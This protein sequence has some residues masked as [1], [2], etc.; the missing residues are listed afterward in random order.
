MY[1]ESSKDSIVEGDGFSIVCAASKF[2]YSNVSWGHSS[3]SLLEHD[4]DIK[5]EYWDTNY[6]LWSNISVMAGSKTTHSGDFYCNAERKVNF[7]ESKHSG[8]SMYLPLIVG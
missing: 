6:S 7:V 8:L 2:R 1:L 4:K 3:I 5:I